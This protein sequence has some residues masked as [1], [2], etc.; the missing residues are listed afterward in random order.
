MSFA[1]VT[2]E[3]VD[4]MTYDKYATRTANS[5]E[6]DALKDMF[7]VY[8]NRDTYFMPSAKYTR[9]LALL[10]AHHYALDDT[11]QPDSG[12]PDNVVGPVTSEKVGNLSQSRG[13]QPYIGTVPGSKT[14]LMSSKWG[15]EF[16]Y[17]MKTFKPTPMVT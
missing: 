9:G 15:V 17:L 12:G 6:F 4:L 16:L 13:L 3:Y 5:T 14:W 2:P 7:I 10:I 11:Q 1:D 8:L